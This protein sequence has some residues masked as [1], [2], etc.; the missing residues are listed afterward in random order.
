MRLPCGFSDE[1]EGDVETE[2][3]DG[4]TVR[5]HGDNGKDLHCPQFVLLN[6]MAH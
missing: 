4:K 3:T 1:P 2:A 5:G 6:K